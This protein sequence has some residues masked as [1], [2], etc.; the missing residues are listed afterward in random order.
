MITS[1]PKTADSRYDVAIIGAG[2]IG[3]S[4]ADAL[5]RRGL[6]ILVADIADQV[7]QG[8]SFSNSGMIHP[9]QSWPWASLGLSDDARL[10]AA[11]DV[12]GLAQSS[13]DILKARA[14]ELDL[15]Q[16]RRSAGCLQI[17]RGDQARDAACERF[18]A[19]DIPYE[20]RA[21]GPLFG[22]QPAVY[23]PGDTSGNAYEYGTA[24]ADDVRARGVDISLGQGASLW[25]DDGRVI[26]LRLGNQDVSA[27]HVIMAAGMQSARLTSWA[28]LTLPM[29]RAIGWAVN[30]E[31][32]SQEAS[33]FKLPDYPVM[34]AGSCSA[35]TV[36]ENT[37]RL[38]GTID[39]PDER[40]LLSLWGNIAPKLMPRLST[41]VLAPWRGERPMSLT[42]KPFIGRSAVPGLWLNTAHGHMGWTLCAGAGELLA[43]M[44]AEGH[45]DERFGVPS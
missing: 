34:E 10:R 28:G 3:L 6:K 30:F 18:D 40:G 29:K 35:L 23:F 11:R 39:L 19:I 22:D 33:G 4:S 25:Q 14:S 36:F 7:M 27:D 41:P 45:N 42:G 26:G 31:R 43:D 37:V 38:S 2:L 15:L 17:F 21:A 20:R 5:A 16:S 32:P 9:S 12:A 44:I 8:A 24:L 1:T 13:A